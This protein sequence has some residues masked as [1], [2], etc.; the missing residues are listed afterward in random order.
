MKNYFVPTISIAGVNLKSA[1][2]FETLSAGVISMYVNGT[3]VYN[4]IQ[5]DIKIDHCV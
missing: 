2:Y 4:S 5:T 1:I 3:Y